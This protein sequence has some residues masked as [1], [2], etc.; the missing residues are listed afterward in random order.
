MNRY[1]QLKTE[2]KAAPRR[3]LVTGVAGFIGSHLVEELL[4][5]EQRVV[6]LDNFAT[7]H[8]RNLDDVKAKVS[9]GQWRNFTFLEADIRRIEDCHRACDNI[10]IALH[11]AALGSVPRSL[12]NPLVSHSANVNGF[13]NLIVAARDAGVKRLVYASS[14]SV[15]GDEPLLPKLEQNIGRPLSPYAATKLIDEIYADVFSRCYGISAIGLRYFNVFGPRQDPNGAY[16]AVIPKWINAMLSG[17]KI[18]INGDGQTSRDFC[19]ISNVVQA[20]I[21]AGTATSREA[22]NRIYNIACGQ[23][24]TLRQLHAQITQMMQ[25]HLKAGAVPEF[26][27]APERTGDVR[28]SVANI[29]AACLHLGYE[30]THFIEA[31]LTEAAAWYIDAFSGATSSG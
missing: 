31:G 23:R 7:G 27:F 21:L 2:L 30:P 13:L 3:W 4:R 16:A 19:Y 6:G 8:R 11:Q 28:H 12:E 14:S 5:L 26:D 17:V 29:D 22:Q 1:E 10:D 25:S 15:Y 9:E 20:N 18:S 24:T